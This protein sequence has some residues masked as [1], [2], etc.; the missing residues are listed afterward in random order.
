LPAIFDQARHGREISRY[1]NGFSMFDKDGLRL[2]T[3]LRLHVRA[4]FVFGHIQP[5]HSVF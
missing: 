1:S 4:V 3:A 5:N 2:V